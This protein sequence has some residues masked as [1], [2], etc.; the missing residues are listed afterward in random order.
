MCSRGPGERAVLGAKLKC[1]GDYGAAACDGN[2]R[3]GRPPEGSPANSKFMG[4]KERVPTFLPLNT[5][6]HTSKAGD[7]T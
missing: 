1:F 7:E 3:L 2:G 6:A 5:S 4:F